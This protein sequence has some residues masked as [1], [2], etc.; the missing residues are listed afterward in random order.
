M[1]IESNIYYS[2]ESSPKILGMWQRRQGGI[3][4]W[5]LCERQ[6]AGSVRMSCVPWRE[7]LVTNAQS[8]WMP[9]SPGYH[10]GLLVPAPASSCSY[11][12]I[13]CSWRVTLAKDDIESALERN[14]RRAA[15]W[16][17]ADHSHA[18]SLLYC[19][20]VWP[21]DDTVC[22]LRVLLALSVYP[23]CSVD[24]DCVIKIYYFEI[25]ITNNVICACPV[26]PISEYWHHCRV[27][28]VS[29]Y[30]Y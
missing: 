2:P 30:W 14:R 4:Y 29:C 11:S 8:G 17:P 28:F 13:R 12:F 3:Q 19:S 22:H 26:A 16:W 27:F 24:G 7:P 9:A 10:N 21:R 1:F 15:R 23:V 6:I 25:V 18:M 20:T 5:V